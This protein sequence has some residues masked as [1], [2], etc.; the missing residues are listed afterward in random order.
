MNECEKILIQFNLK[1]TEIS[2]VLL[3]IT[4]KNYITNQSFQI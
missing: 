3:Y 2:V 1:T 4:F